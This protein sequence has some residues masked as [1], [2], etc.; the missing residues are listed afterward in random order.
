MNERHTTHF[1]DCG[2]L[3]ER[4]SARAETAER[5]LSALRAWAQ[6]AR[7][8]M[9]EVIKALEYQQSPGGIYM[10]DVLVRAVNWRATT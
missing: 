8:A 2:C 10:A 7:S 1:D 6:N 9:T 5:E 3:S 4:L